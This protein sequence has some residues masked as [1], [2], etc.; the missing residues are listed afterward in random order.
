[1]RQI[2]AIIESHRQQTVPIQSMPLTSSSSSSQNINQSSTHS[3]RWNRQ[4]LYQTPSAPSCA[5]HTV[6]R[7][8]TFFPSSYLLIYLPTYLPTYLPIYNIPKHE[9]IRK[10]DKTAPHT[11]IHDESKSDARLRR[12]IFEKKLKKLKKGGRKKTK[13]S[14]YAPLSS[15]L[16]RRAESA[17]PYGA[18][19]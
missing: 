10:H 2:C 11:H 1:M 17:L 13:L 5:I 6:V 19:M 15:Y 7:P 9:N 3:N 12:S 14:A 16:M 18:M 8:R 4:L